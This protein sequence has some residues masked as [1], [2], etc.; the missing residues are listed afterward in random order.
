MDGLKPEKLEKLIGYEFADKTLLTRALTHTSHAYETS[1]GHPKDN[2]L[3]E[4]LG[5]SVVGLVTAEFYHGAFPGRSEGELSKLKASA[6]STIALARL[7]RKV[8]LDKAIRLGRGEERSGGRKKS[9]ILA[10]ALE[11]LAGAVF[12]DGG[13]EAAR[14][15]FGGLLRDSI[16]PFRGQALGI[17][18]AKSALQEWLQKA[19]RPAP[20]YRLLSE[21][22]PSHD[23]TFV[24]EVAVE[25]SPLAKA[26][27]ASK[28]LAEQKAAEKALKSHFGRRLKRISPEALLIE[29]VD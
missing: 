19:G 6:T 13:F 12:L 9:S 23:R 29:P 28:K 4:F 8:K 27:G 17:N 7:A 10:G 2:E 14:Y 1:P 26:R 5:D 18:N 11:A 16:E 22:G 3:L 24:V 25:D 15:F 20:T 21:C